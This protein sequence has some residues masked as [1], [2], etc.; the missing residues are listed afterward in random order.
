M[1][2]TVKIA[3]VSAV[4]AALGLTACTSTPDQNAAAQTPASTPSTSVITEVET[5]TVT[6]PPEQADSRPGYGALKLGMTLEEARA[7]GQTNLSF[8][9]GNPF[10]VAD[11]TVAISKQDGVSRITLPADGR[12]SKGIAIGYGIDQVRMAYPNAQEYRA[13]LSA[14]LDGY[15][16]AFVIENDSVVAIKL[17]SNNAAS[18]CDQADL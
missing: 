17:L 2:N 18:G 1:K 15:S 4:A 6:N 8:S 5:A 7:T 14:Q 10:C 11:G 13:G 16:Y 3:F 9:E 12:T